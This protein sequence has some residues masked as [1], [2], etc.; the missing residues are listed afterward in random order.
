[1]V[2][3]IIMFMIRGAQPVALI[4]AAHSMWP[5]ARRS[6]QTSPRSIDFF[7]NDICK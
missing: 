3:I 7:K 6:Y 4:I 2:A 5:C 1:M